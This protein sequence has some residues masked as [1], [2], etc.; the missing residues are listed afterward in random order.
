ME[1]VKRPTTSSI[2]VNSKTPLTLRQLEK[3]RKPLQNRVVKAVS[4]S[5]IFISGRTENISR[6][7][8]A[9]ASL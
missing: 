5:Y 3:A 4:A 7:T 2:D 6:H 9:T 8:H 1:T